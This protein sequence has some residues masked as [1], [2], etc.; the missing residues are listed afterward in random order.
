[1]LR[2]FN[3]SCRRVDR[4]SS[5]WKA[6][7]R[8]TH[9][10]TDRRTASVRL[11]RIRLGSDSNQL[12]CVELRGDAKPPKPTRGSAAWMPKIEGN[13]MLAILHKIIVQRSIAGDRVFIGRSPSVSVSESAPRS[14][15]LQ[16]F[17]GTAPMTTL[18]LHRDEQIAIDAPAACALFLDFLQTEFGEGEILWRYVANIY[19]RLAVARGWP[20]LSDKALSQ[21][22]TSLGCITRQRDLRSEGLG[23]PRELVWPGTRVVGTLKQAA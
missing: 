9:P 6:P 13:T 12:R 8:L 11:G 15:F 18:R 20:V 21:G 5:A 19:S 7:T 1:M 10:A 23:R 14:E 16:A 22:L 2:S 17:P 3:G 4:S